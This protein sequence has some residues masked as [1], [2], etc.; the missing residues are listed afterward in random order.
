[1]VEIVRRH[2]M[3]ITGPN[4]L[5]SI[6]PPDG[7]FGTFSSLLATAKPP[8]GIVGVATQSGAYGSHIYAVAGFRGIGI[9]RAIA[10]EFK[11]NEIFPKTDTLEDWLKLID[12][13]P[14]NVVTV[15]PIRANNREKQLSRRG[16][17]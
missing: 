7:Y 12:Y 2:G 16:V 6:S 5:G 8:P 14:E 10:T 15:K 13:E 3:R 9:S 1:M 11:E 17:I 4:C